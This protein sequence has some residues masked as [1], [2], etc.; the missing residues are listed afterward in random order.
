[1][2]DPFTKPSEARRDTDE[3]RR[4]RLADHADRPLMIDVEGGEPMPYDEETPREA[5]PSAA[6]HSRD[7][8]LP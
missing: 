6:E 2:P 8:R 4:A 5:G 3:F 1:M 7:Q